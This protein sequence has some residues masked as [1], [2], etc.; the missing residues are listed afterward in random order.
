MNQPYTSIIILTLALLI[1]ITIGEPPLK[2]H[3]VV[4]IGKLINYLEQYCH[5]GTP[6]T[7]KIKGAIM[8]LSVIT[9][10]GLTSW[11]ILKLTEVY[12]GIYAYIIISALLLKTTFALKSMKTHTLP[13]AQALE[14]ND[15]QYARIL[16]S[17]VVRRNPW[18]LTN[19]QVISATIE[20]IAEGIVDG[21]TSTLF[22]YSLFGIPG[23][24][25]QR[26]INTLDSMVGYKDE[27]YKNVGWFSAKLDTI[28]NFIPARLTTIMIT[29]AA[30]ILKKDYK[31]SLKTALTNHKNTES[32]NAGWPMSAMAGALRIQLEKPGYY[33][34]GKPLQ[35]L[36]PKH[37]HDALRIMYISTILFI[38]LLILPTL[39]IIPILMNILKS[40]AFVV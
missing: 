36:T 27:Y 20:T 22:Y 8:A 29:L 37:I 19:E 2:I 5:G 15:T 40:E 28:A 1:D 12:L 3:P 25:I 33:T 6:N 26:T 35:K 23:A 32:L 38:I 4:W 34:L 30:L 13:I 39:I 7:E 17:R 16:L 14:K 31:L 9:L 10:T 11:L 18:K 24:I 21:I